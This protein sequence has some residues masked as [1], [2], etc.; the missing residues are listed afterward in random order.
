MGTLDLMTVVVHNPG[1]TYFDFFF[2][3]ISDVLWAFVLIG[4]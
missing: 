3:F 1:E 2:I 4:N